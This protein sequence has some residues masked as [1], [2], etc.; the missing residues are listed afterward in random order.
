M[1]KMIISG[2]S[3]VIGAI[4][5]FVF[6]NNDSSKKSSLAS[7]P[8]KEI[9]HKIKTEKKSSIPQTSPSVKESSRKEVL[10]HELNDEVPL[11]KSQKPSLSLKNKERLITLTH[12]LNA[13]NHC[14]ESKTCP[15]DNSDPRA[16]ELLLGQ[17]IAQQ[18][19]EYRLIRESEDHFDKKS[20]EMVKTFLS[21][22]DGHVQ[23]EA[24]HLMSLHKAS[25]ELGRSLI[26]VLK[27]TFDAK[28]MNQSLIEL[29]RYPSLSHEIQTLLSNTLKTGS[30]YAAQEVASNI[31]PFLN[32]TNIEHYIKVA[33]ALPKDSNKARALHSNIKEYQLSEMGG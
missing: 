4:I 15:V 11:P 23:E 22:P 20:L 19:K 33:N 18:L 13:L 31:L 21:Y 1:K 25:D 29:Q 17:T 8:Q 27:K 16:S 14:D 32:K 28:I 6:L 3:I 9:R 10:A 7:L 12:S 2:L 30:F 24:I 5:A 26:T